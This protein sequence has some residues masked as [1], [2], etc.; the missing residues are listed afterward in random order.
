VRRRRRGRGFFAA[1]RSGSKDRAGLG[2]VTSG[3]AGPSN[4][5]FD[6]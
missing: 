1:G 4:G 6:V 2:D 3:R 5:G